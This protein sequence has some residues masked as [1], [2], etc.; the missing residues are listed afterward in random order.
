M[1]TILLW[2]GDLVVDVQDVARQD[3]GAQLDL[4]NGCG[5]HVEAACAPICTRIEA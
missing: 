2:Q 4:P 5:Q 3:G 1:V